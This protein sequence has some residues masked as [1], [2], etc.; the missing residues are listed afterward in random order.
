MTLQGID[1]HAWARHN[2]I[3]KHAINQDLKNQEIPVTEVSPDNTLSPDYIPLYVNPDPTA[4][5]MDC[6]KFINYDLD[7]GLY[8]GFD[9]KKPGEKTNVYEVLVNFSDEP[10][11]DMDKNLELSFAQRFMAGSQGYRHMYYPFWTFHLPYP[12]ISQGEA[13]Y[14]AQHFFNRAIDEYRNGN[15]YASY[16]ELARS[17]HYVMDM[18]QP[19]HTRQLY[20]RFIQ[21]SSPFDGTI[22]AIKNY[23][24]A[25]ETFIANLLQME[26]CEGGG[27]LIDKIRNAEPLSAD[28]INN[29]AVLVA[30]RSNKM[31][32]DLYRSV[33]KILG[34]RF[35]TAEPEFLTEGEFRNLVDGKSD[36]KELIELSGEALTLASGAVKGV[37]LLFKKNTINNRDSIDRGR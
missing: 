22:Q 13:P 21:F 32:G 2:L 14:R 15:I 29:L 30:I 12:F 6:N 31:A 4:N 17:I 10:D 9:G 23:H 24:F 26:D 20:Y 27:K 33:I 35:N 37:L 25:Y 19:F 3:T 8:Y 18:S 5:S 28:S 36:I 16:R 11:R 1:L 34:D 7:R